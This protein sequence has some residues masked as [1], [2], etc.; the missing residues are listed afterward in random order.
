MLAPSNHRLAAPVQSSFRFVIVSLFAL[1]SVSGCSSAKEQANPLDT[2]QRADKIVISKADHTMT[3]MS[4]GK[5]LSVYKVALGRGPS[6]P[7]EHQGDHETP[8]GEY[9]ID[10]KNPQSRFHL[11]LHVSYPNALDRKRAESRGLDPGG[12]IMIHGVEKHFAWLGS[13][14]HEVDWTDGCIAVTN[15]EIEEV[16]R[17]VP[18]GTPVEILH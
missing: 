5:V 7:K 11:A 17:L 8:E 18:V 15:P 16:Y 4:K 9:V 10:Q 2:E 14:Q 13:L 6:G 12:A 1:L 3:L